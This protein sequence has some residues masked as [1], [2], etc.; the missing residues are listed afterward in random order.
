M[1][2]ALTTIKEKMQAI[3]KNYADK[4]QQETEN[5]QK[6]M[7]QSESTFQASIQG[8]KKKIETLNSMH[9][10]EVK[11]IFEDEKTLSFIKKMRQF[12]QDWQ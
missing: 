10:Q 7:S 9:S 8:E 5:H 6:L 3:Q 4:L 11:D 12:K 2:N 1:G